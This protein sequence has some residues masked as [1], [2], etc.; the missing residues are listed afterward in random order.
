MFHTLLTTC[1]CV[2]PEPRIICIRCPFPTC[3]L[4]F[5]ILASDKQARL[6]ACRVSTRAASP[7]NWF[8]LPTF[9]SPPNPMRRSSFASRLCA[10]AINARGGCALPRRVRVS[11]AS[12]TQMR[13]TRG[14]A[15]QCKCMYINTPRHWLILKR[16]APHRDVWALKHSRVALTIICW[17]WVLIINVSTCFYAVNT[18]D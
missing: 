16:K 9:H 8:S 13:E 10:D 17:L 12:Y 1:L 6:A 15:R 11:L 7:A 3:F 18:S 5:N 4:K 14:F 2:G